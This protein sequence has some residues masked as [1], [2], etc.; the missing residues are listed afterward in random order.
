MKLRN[1]SGDRQVAKE[2]EVIMISSSNELLGKDPE[3]ELVRENL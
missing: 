3:L 2:P 1:W